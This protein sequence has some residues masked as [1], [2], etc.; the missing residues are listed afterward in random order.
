MLVKIT[1]S[2]TTY[3][4]DGII[5]SVNHVFDFKAQ[6]AFKTLRQKH[7]RACYE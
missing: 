5:Q 6:R 2:D 4:I 3:Q 7:E 1:L